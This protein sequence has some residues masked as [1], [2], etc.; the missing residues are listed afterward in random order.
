MPERRRQRPPVEVQH[1]I[2]KALAGLI[3]PAMASAGLAAQQHGAHHRRGRERNRQRNHDRDRDRHR[4]FAEQPADNAA[5]QQDR[6]EDRNQRD[7][8]REHGEADF[9]GAL[10]RGFQRRHPLF[11]VA[12]DVLQHDDGIVDHEARRHR[13]RHQRQ[14]VE[15]VADQV[16]RR[17][18]RDQRHRNRDHRHQRRAEVAQECEHHEDHQQHREDQGSFDVAQRGANGGRAV[19]RQCDVDGRRNRGFQLWQQRLHA[20]T[21]LMMLAPGC[22]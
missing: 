22:R 6:N 5:H 17:E 11:D 8:H 21:V 12:G 10:E 13:K 7:A 15:A 9:V 20:S 19:D 18:G 2:E 4:E 3:K 16:H 14:I 1:P